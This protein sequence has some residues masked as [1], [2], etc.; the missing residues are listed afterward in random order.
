[1]LYQTLTEAA[2]KLQAAGLIRY[3]HGR[4]S[5]VNCAG[6]VAK[7]CECHALVGRGYQRLIG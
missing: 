1:M 2:G 5:L 6:L 3:A 7:A 4:I